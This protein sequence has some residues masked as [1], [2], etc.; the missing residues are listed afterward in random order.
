MRWRRNYDKA[1]SVTLK[2]R[3]RERWINK[4]REMA[5]VR[6]LIITALHCF[7]TAWKLW[8]IQ[9]KVSFPLLRFLCVSSELWP[10]FWTMQSSCRS[11]FIKKI[12]MST[13]GRSTRIFLF[14]LVF[15]NLHSFIADLPDFTHEN[16]HL[17]HT[18]CPRIV[19]CWLGFCSQCS[20]SYSLQLKWQFVWARLGW[21]ADLEKRVRGMY[22]QV[23]NGCLL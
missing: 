19:P 12:D 20:S 17:G 10:W 16:F 4:G 3:N 8:Q 15:I 1:P 13:I 14:C 9:W 2:H 7:L 22:R 6:H 21:Q 23:E 11:H 5:S 18:F